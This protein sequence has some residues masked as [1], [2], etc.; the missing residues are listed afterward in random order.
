MSKEDSKIEPQKIE[1]GD[2]HRP[3]GDDFK[4]EG[5]LTV[6]VFQDEDNII[7]ESTV[8]GV[9]PDDMEVNITNDSV[10]IRG[11]RKRK[12]EIE[13]KD[14]YYQELFWGDFS[15]TVILP[16]DIDPE[17]SDANFSNGILTITMP[18]LKKRKAKKVKV[19][20]E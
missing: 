2:N 7:V 8:A 18:I 19:K 6:D 4:S 11:K 16:H 9:D 3:L 1:M 14:F 10:S 13:E 20:S 5:Q 17:E 15:R 12:K